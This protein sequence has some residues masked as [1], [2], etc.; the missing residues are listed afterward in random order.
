V[1]RGRLFWGG[2][3][4]GKATAVGA[5]HR[6]PQCCTLPGSPSVQSPSLPLWNGTF[7]FHFH[8]LG[9][10]LTSPYTPPSSSDIHVALSQ[11]LLCRNQILLTS[12]AYPAL[13]RSIS[14][15]RF[16]HLTPRAILSNCTFVAKL[17]PTEYST[18]R[19]SNGCRA[20]M[21]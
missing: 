6:L 2:R 17:V 4:A 19:H 20:T 10:E 13:R 3:V 8:F 12:C 15:L 9:R 21:A 14:Q 5:R 7:H 11:F 1:V 18:V 16:N